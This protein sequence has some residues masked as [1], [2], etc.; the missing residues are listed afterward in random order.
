MQSPSCFQRGVPTALGLEEESPAPRP[1]TH[2]R[3][4]ACGSA[5][6]KLTAPRRTASA[7]SHRRAP[8]L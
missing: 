2:A 5:L 6:P 7:Q 1:R 8:I 4:C 3:T